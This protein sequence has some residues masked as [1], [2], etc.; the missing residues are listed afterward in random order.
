[1]YIIAGH[2]DVI[3]AYQYNRTAAFIQIPDALW[4]TGVIPGLTQ[5]QPVMNV[6]SGAR[7]RGAVRAE[8]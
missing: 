5:Y 3:Q 6:D 8:H 1:M 7:V 2:S 4:S